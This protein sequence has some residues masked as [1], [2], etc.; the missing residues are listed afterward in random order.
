MTAAGGL[1]G[2][3]L[4]AYGVY[5][6]RDGHV[7]VAALEP[8]FRARLYDALALPLDAP[9]AE[10]MATR[11]TAEWDA[12]AA[13]TRPPHRRRPLPALSRTDEEPGDCAG[14]ADR[15]S[16]S[17]CPEHARLLAAWVA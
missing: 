4:P 17:D 12:F 5:A 10:V 15:L 14:P 8:H 7:A 6:A 13:T 3:G 1:L 2:G 9:L 11:T 16:S